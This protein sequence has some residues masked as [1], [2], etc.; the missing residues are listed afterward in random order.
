MSEQV[1]YIE[2]P[3]LSEIINE[4][5][6][7]LFYNQDRYLL[8]WGGRGS[9]K[10]NFAAKKIIYDCL[11]QSY[12]RFIL[13]RDTYASIK[14][15]QYQT[16]KDVVSEFGLQPFFQFKENPLEIKCIN[17]NMIYA[18]GCDDV[19]KIKSIKDP[20][21][22]W[23][24]EA[25]NIDLADFITITTSI[26]TD[27]AEFLQEIL[28]FNPEDMPDEEDQ[29][30]WIDRVFLKG[31]T[32]KHHRGFIEIDLPSGQTLK[33]PFTSHH[34]TYQDNKW[35]NAQFIAFLEQ[36]LKI[37]PYY[38]DVFCLGNRGTRK[39]ESP[40]AHQYDQASHESTEAVFHADT[41]LIIS[42][43]FNVSPFAV[44]FSHIWE[45][46]RGLHD[47]TFDEAAIANGS[48]PAMID[49]IKQRYSPF[50]H[51]CLLTGDASGNARQL[52]MRDQAS[53]Y[54]QLKAGLNLRD[55]QIKIAGNP[56]HKQSYQDVNYLLYQ[57]RIDYSKG[58]P[59]AIDFKI[60]PKSCPHTC[61]DMATVQFNQQKM[62]IIK[63][64]RKDETQRADFL[65]CQRYKIHLL[66]R[67]WIINHQKSQHY[68]P[69]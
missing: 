50:L 14:D 26:R 24:E 66:W 38:Y 57:S 23:Y 4:R 39:G 54:R 17:G 52:S 55:S 36:L 63:S 53:Y 32:H 40:F 46:A 51:T 12:Y 60:N 27:K 68:K 58:R 21:G 22:A 18:R 43:D 62:E 56:T 3:P 37:D 69:R 45:D 7:P 13:I 61:R 28:S 47:H 33:T 48:I 5:F 29:W 25:N 19:E 16:I 9:S 59:P 35:C 2:F 49:L 67:K 31:E 8:L 64:N 20:S 1:S 6:K 34:S 42:I 44:N 65:D 10:S 11:S 15:S 30:H 41:Q